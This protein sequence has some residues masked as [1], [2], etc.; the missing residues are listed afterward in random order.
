MTTLVGFI[1]MVLSVRLDGVVVDGAVD[2]LPGLQPLQILHHQLR[3][4][5]VGV[6]VVLLAPL[7]EGTVLPLVVVVVMHHADVRSERWAR[8]SV[9]VVLPEP[10]PPAM[11]M[12]MV[13]IL[14]VPLLV[15][16]FPL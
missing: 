13:F 14:V 3:V 9:R 12:K 16:S 6:V 10:V 4:E 11:P 15:L 5:G 2:G 1:S 7:L 8:C